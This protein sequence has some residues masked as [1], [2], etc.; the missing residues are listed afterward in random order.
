MNEVIPAI[1]AQSFEEILEKIKLIEENLMPLDN[2]PEWVH[3]DVAD[4]TFT[5]NIIWHN[6]NDLKN[7]NTDLKIEMH[8]MINDI[9]L[10]ITDWL[11][12]TIS[13]NIFHLEAAS[14]PDYIVEKCDA[15]NIKAGIAINPSTPVTDLFKYCN[16]VDL[17]QTLAVCP[18]VAGQLFDERIYNKISKLR[19]GCKHANI[20]V[21]GG[22][23]EGVARE[24]KN[25]GANTFVAA[26]SIF[27]AEDIKQAYT[28]LK[29]NV[30]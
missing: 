25:N 26:S 5:K 29:L 27:N 7:L 4:G 2:G 18:G 10:R 16:K 12:K 20:E 28:K 14:N 24:C 22:I 3:I 1:N 30:E 8:L 13:R 9:D 23:N 15:S 21:D 19:T 11:D 6:F 17:L